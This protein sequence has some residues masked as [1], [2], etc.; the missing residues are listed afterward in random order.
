MPE[1]P[2]LLCSIS[3]Q[4]APSLL[5]VSLLLFPEKFD[6]SKIVCGTSCNSQ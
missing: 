3:G 2:A 6:I 1:L 5:T 4:L